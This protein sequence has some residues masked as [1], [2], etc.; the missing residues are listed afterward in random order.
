MF[1]DIVYLSAHEVLDRYRDGSLSPADYIAQLQRHVALVQPRVNATTGEQLPLAD[2]IAES[3]RRW[4]DGTERP[5][6]GLPVIVKEAQGIEGHTVTLGSP[7]INEVAETTHPM[8]ERIIEAGGIPFLRSTTPE[9]C[10][11]AYTRTQMW[12]TSRNPWN[13]EYAVGGSSGGSGAALAG[14][15]APLATGSDIGGSTRIPASMNG[16]VGYKPPFG[17]VPTV[18]GNY[19]DDFC[20]D[21]PMARTVLDVALMQNVIAGQHPMDHMSLPDRE[22]LAP[23]ADLTGRRIAV[24]TTFGDYKVSPEV[25]AAVAGTIEWLRAAGATVKEVE[26]PL[27]HRWVADTAWAHFGSSFVP[28]IESVIGENTDLVEPPT[29]EA[30]A[31]SRDAASRIDPLEVEERKIHVHLV[32]AELFQRFDALVCPVASVPA[33]KADEGYADGITL[34]GDHHASHVEAMLTIPFNIANRN[35]VLSVP[36]A[37]SSDNVPIGVQ[38]VARPY[39]DATVFDVG[40]ALEQA[41]GEWYSTAAQRPVLPAA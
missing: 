7:L 37:R 15:Y 10:I 13:A 38:V 34:D 17:R 24:A 1:S 12:G 8:V 5:L 30:I 9:Y 35:P 3:T 20:T 4:A 40:L 29:L 36:I 41:R 6:E 11:A 19:M 23:N 18:P 39:D 26:V 33:L 27:D 25:R 2:A 22:P 16:V 31:L 21:G 28:W 32:F 14:G